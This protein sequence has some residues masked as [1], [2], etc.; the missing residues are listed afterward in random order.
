M[1]IYPIEMQIHVYLSDRPADLSDRSVGL[2]NRNTSALLSDRSWNYLIEMHI[3]GTKEN[4]RKPH[5]H[6]RSSRVRH[7]ERLFSLVFRDM[8]FYLIDLV[9]RISIALLSDRKPLINPR[10]SNRNTC[11]QVY[12]IEMQG[13]IQ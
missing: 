2:S 7:W 13:I 11:M 3:P 8:H 10:L 4:Q 12:P 6:A 1:Q 5:I 9:Y